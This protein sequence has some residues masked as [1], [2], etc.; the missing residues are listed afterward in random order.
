MKKCYFAL[1]AMTLIAQHAFAFAP[2]ELR[3][4]IGKTVDLREINFDEYLKTMAQGKLIS[5]SRDG[6][7]CFVNFSEGMTGTT[8][9][10]CSALTDP[11]A[12]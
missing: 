6:K 10:S 12:K 1:L 7:I 3:S 8:D 5:F 9:V 4:R 2:N 11:Q